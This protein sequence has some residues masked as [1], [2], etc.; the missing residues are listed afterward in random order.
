MNDEQPRKSNEKGPLI[1][2]S[3]SFSEWL[4]SADVTLAITTYQ[5]GRLFFIGRKAEG[6]DLPLS[7]SSTWS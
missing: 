4:A 2:L 7:F 1:L 6:G 3:S 5:A